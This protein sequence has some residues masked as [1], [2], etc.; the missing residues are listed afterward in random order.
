MPFVAM[1]SEIRPT[2]ILMLRDLS[3]RYD[4]RSCLPLQVAN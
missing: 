1:K 2:A 3:C 4:P